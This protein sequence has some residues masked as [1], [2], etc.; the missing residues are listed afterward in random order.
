[1]PVA[2]ENGS[3]MVRTGIDAAFVSHGGNQKQVVSQILSIYIYIN[4]DEDSRR[5][6][7]ARLVGT[8]IRLCAGLRS[9]A[10]SPSPP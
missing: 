7:C 3:P 10:I 5:R 6:N 9:M 2:N 1:M 4:N 8:N